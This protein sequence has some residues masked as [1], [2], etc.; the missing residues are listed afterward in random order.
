MTMIIKNKPLTLIIMNILFFLWI[1]LWKSVGYE[2]F[3]GTELVK[4]FIIL[5]GVPVIWLLIQYKMKV[6]YRFI[7]LLLLLSIIVFFSIPYELANSLTK[8]LSPLKTSLF[9]N[10]CS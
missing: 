7:G 9:K 5:I 4:Y 3:E 8:E 1:I 2:C 10:F 6:N